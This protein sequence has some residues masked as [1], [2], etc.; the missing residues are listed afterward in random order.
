MEDINRLLEESIGIYQTQIRLLDSLEEAIAEHGP[1]VAKEYVRGRQNLVAN[2]AIGEFNKTST[3]A[4]RTVKTI[5][6]LLELL[7]TGEEKHDLKDL[8]ESIEMEDYH[9]KED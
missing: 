9:G 5:L 6:R 2:P 8:I 3:A 4:N 7:K 1:I